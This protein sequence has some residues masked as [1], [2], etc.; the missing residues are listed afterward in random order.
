MATPG[1][2]ALAMA[3]TVHR[4][5]VEQFL[6]CAATV[7]LH[8]ARDVLGDLLPGDPPATG[9]GHRPVEVAGLPITPSSWPASTSAEIRAS[10]ARTVRSRSFPIP[11]MTLSPHGA[12]VQ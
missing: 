4:E 3:E 2:V 12:E 8:E 7:S 9:V 10:P 11:I 6:C 1:D 5:Q